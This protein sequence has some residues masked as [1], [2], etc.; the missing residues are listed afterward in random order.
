MPAARHVHADAAD[1]R[2]M[3]ALDCFA[4]RLETP[5]IGHG[6]AAIPCDVIRLSVAVVVDVHVG[7]MA[8]HV[9][10]EVGSAGSVPAGVV[11]AW[12]AKAAH[13]VHAGDLHALPL[14]LLD[15]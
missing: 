7:R 14:E 11:V 13:D 8:V 12:R 4:P 15:G 3:P 10:A 9:T 1:E 2:A 5:S 6:H